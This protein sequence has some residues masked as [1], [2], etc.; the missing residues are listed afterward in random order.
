MKQALIL[1]GAALAIV[2]APAAAK[3]AHAGGHGKHK[4][5][6]ERVDRDYRDY[7]DTRDYYAERDGRRCPPG[8][9]KK[10]NGCLPPGQAKKLVRGQRYASSYGYN[11]Y[12]YN[13]IPYD[14]RRQYDLDPYNQYYYDGG[15]LYGV[16]PRTMIVEQV[17]R[18]ILR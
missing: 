4:D 12:A 11:P 16:D 14:L 13:S 17:I 9:A 15:N 6:M 1:A 10:N 5:R 18:A 8:L 3:P 7:R 2:A